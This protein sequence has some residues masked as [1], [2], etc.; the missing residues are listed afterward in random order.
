MVGVYFA[1]RAADKGLKIYKTMQR[2]R[3]YPSLGTYCVLLAGLEKL[4]RV[5]KAETYRKEKKSLQKDAYFRESIPI[6][7]KICDLLFAKD[8]VS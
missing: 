3:F 6:E 4:G 7:E 5:S 1:A 8:V 2:K